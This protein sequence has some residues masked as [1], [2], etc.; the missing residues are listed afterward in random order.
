MGVRGSPTSEV[1]VRG[2]VEGLRE[3]IALLGQR[4]GIF[5]ETPPRVEELCFSNVLN[6]IFG[7]YSIISCQKKN[8]KKNGGIR[9]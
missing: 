3:K 9:F 7:K 4:Q 2:V 6:A 1:V 5:K 8:F